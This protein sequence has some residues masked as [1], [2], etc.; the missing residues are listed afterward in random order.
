MGWS[1]YMGAGSWETAWKLQIDFYKRDYPECHKSRLLE[2]A[3][4]VAVWAD[5]QQHPPDHQHPRLK[6]L[7]RGGAEGLL[8]HR[9]MRHLL[10][11][12]YSAPFM[13]PLDEQHLV[14]VAC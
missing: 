3:S 13:V 10:L 9:C 5:V 8:S 12:Q 2:D 1:P 7:N 14:P 11:P 4:D 6:S